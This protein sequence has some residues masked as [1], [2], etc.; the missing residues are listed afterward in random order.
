[1]SEAVVM[2]DKSSD[3]YRS[4]VELGVPTLSMVEKSEGYFTSMTSSIAYHMI[5]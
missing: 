5:T 1:V 2:D 3:N 4:N